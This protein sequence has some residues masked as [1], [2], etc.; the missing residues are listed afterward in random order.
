MYKWVSVDEKDGTSTETSKSVDM[1]SDSGSVQTQSEVHDSA[2][3]ERY[4]G[5]CV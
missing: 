5:G 1:T 3:A 4:I 2:P